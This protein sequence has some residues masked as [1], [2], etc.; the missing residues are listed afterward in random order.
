[1][2]DTALQTHLSAMQS[3]FI[4]YVDLK[5]EQLLYDFR[6]IFGDRTEQ[7]NGKIADHEE[8]IHVV[9][10]ALGLAA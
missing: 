7:Q 1:M 3:E 10:T 6:G 2:L 5:H 8:R 9:E 4:S